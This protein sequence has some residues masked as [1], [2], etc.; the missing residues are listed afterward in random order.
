MTTAP[1]TS[2]NGLDLLRAVAPLVSETPGIARLLGMDVE[3]MG[4]GRQIA[5]TRRPD[6][7]NT[8]GDVHGGI[9]ATL[10][11]TVTDYAVHTT[12]E[13][14]VGCSTL[15]RT[16][17]V[18]RA[19]SRPQGADRRPSGRPSTSVAAPRPRRARFATRGRLVA[20]GTMMPDSAM[21]AAIDLGMDTLRLEQDGRVLT[22][23][24]SNPPSN[25]VKAALLR[26]LDLL[27]RTVE[28][29]NTVGAVAI[30]SDVAGRFLSHVDANELEALSDAP[31]PE[32]GVSGSAAWTV[33]NAALGL[34][35]TKRGARTW[36]VG[37]GLL[38]SHR[39]KKAVLPD[40]PVALRSRHGPPWAVG[41]SSR[42]R[43]T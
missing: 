28:D 20:H 42:S 22:A 39:W 7:A 14:G 36:H 10:L 5:L 37:A 24:Y 43:A 12:L 26:D 9:C 25:Y 8:A 3:L 17:S 11:D 33:I 38:T 31:G 34:G 23:Y 18:T 2:L 41:M 15:W 19:P 40:E 6:F 29:D 13:A 4:E 32:L 27:T 30:A 21:S 35:A 1:E 16:R